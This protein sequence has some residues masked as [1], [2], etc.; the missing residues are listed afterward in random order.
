MFLGSSSSLSST[1][2]QLKVE[3]R[4]EIPSSF[5]TKDP[6]IADAGVKGKYKS[7]TKDT[8]E[9]KEQ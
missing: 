4:K 5:D 7:V 3:T 2:G 8:E 6:K 9:E 1:Q